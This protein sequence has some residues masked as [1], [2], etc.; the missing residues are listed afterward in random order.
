MDGYATLR[1]YGPPIA[2]MS[3]AAGLLHTVI[4]KYDPLGLADAEK[5]LLGHAQTPLKSYF[6]QAGEHA[7]HTVIGGKGPPLVMLH[8]HGNGVGGWFSNYDALAKHFRIYAIDW[9]GWGRSD[10][11]SFEGKTAQD[12]LDWWLASFEAWRKKMGLTNFFL[13]GHSLGGWLA[14]QYALNYG[15]HIRQLLLANPA[16]IVDQLTM[17][18]GLFYYISPQRIMRA[19]GPLGARLME[20]SYSEQVAHLDGGNDLLAYYYHL[21][22]APLSGQLAFQR[23]LSLNPLKWSLPLEQQVS[24]LSVPTKLIWGVNDPLFPIELA[25]LLRDRLPQADFIP[26][27]KAG[28]TS[29]IEDPQGFNEAM[30]RIRHETTINGGFNSFSMPIAKA[31]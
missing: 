31:A 21:A 13:L 26:L 23:L 25:H 2:L 30:I 28:H 16:G 11:P 3:G 1:R 24:K 22:K 8:G 14:T 19:A 5:R 10:R 17:R 15:Q 9:L 12:A 4:P 20:H 27:A 7:I 29:F 6:V 18:K